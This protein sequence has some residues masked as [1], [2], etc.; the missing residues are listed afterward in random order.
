M[1]VIT[2]KREIVGMLKPL[3]GNYHLLDEHFRLFNGLYRFKV[4]DDEGFENLASFIGDFVVIPVQV[5]VWI[6]VKRVITEEEAKLLSNEQ[7][8][9]TELTIES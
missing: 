5:P 3:V 4:V 1:K 7:L 2:E 8:A 6:D 9:F